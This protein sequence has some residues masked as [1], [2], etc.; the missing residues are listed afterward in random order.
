MLPQL[1]LLLSL[2]AAH[3][4]SGWAMRAISLPQFGL[5]RTSLG[6][7]QPRCQ[8]DEPEATSREPNSDDS[9]RAR[10]VELVERAGDPF[11]GVRVVLYAVFGVA[12]LAGIATSIMTMGTDPGPAL[13]NIAINSAVL[14]IGVAVYVFDQKITSDLKRKLEEE[15]KNPYLKGDLDGF[16]EEDIK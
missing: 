5:S 2:S 1:P 14:A 8:A 15:L 7:A 4:A 13:G 16:L 10:R 9:L 6:R 12:G 11:R 3:P